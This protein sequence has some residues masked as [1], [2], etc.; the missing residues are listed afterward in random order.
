MR[1]GRID[2]PSTGYTPAEGD[3]MYWDSTAEGW[4]ILNIGTVGQTLT[5]ASGVPDWA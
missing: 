4:V 2:E 3:M 5:V 1:F